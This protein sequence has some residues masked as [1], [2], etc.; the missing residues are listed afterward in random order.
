MAGP[1]QDTG[2]LW[3]ARIFIGIGVVLLALAS[4]GMARQMARGGSEFTT[5]VV[6]RMESAP[7]STDPGLAESQ[8][9]YADCPVVRFTTREGTELEVR[10]ATCASPPTYVV[11][12]SVPV[13]YDSDRPEMA[14]VGGFFTRHMLAVAAAGFAVPFV[15]IGLFVRRF[16]A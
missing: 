15:L 9:R 8:R 10:G 6:V 13:N 7:T 16:M 2:G 14:A 11:G 5:G 4:V 3:F 1:G 12:E